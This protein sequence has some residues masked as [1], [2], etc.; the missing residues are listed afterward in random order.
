MCLAMSG[1]VLIM[2]RG[3]TPLVPVSDGEQTLMSGSVS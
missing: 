2:V 3:H 1:I